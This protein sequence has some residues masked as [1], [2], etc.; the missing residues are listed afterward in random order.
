MSGTV[1]VVDNLQFNVDLV[2][3]I[4]KHGGYKVISAG[5][6]SQAMTMAKK[7]KPDLVLM[8]LQLPEIDGFEITRMLKANPETSSVKVVAFSALAMAADRKKALKAGCIGYI[9]KPVGARELL[10]A[11]KGFIK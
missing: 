11:V 2:K 4:L 8:D 10:G 5:S 7:Y 9:T 6:G 1:L 3:T